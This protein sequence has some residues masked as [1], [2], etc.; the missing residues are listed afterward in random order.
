MQCGQEF[1]NKHSFVRHECVATENAPETTVSA[2]SEHATVNLLCEVSENKGE[3]PCLKFQF[4][5]PEE[6]C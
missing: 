6:N 1:Y 4:V 3:G 5:C 2:A